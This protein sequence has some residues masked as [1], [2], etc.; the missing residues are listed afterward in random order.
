MRGLQSSTPSGGESGGESGSE[1]YYSLTVPRGSNLFAEKVTVDQLPI[2][3]I[4]FP[5]WAMMRQGLK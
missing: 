5:D 3:I 1:L 2:K 4:D